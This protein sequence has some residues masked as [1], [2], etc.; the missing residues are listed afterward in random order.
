MPA[1][2]VRRS[3]LPLLAAA[4]LA[5]AVR[6]AAAH[7]GWS[8]YASDVE[9][10]LTGTV[11]EVYF[12]MPHC[13]LRLGTPEKTWTCVLAPLSRMTNR[14]LPDGSIKAGDTVTLVGYAS[15]TVPD[16]MRAE[17][18]TVAGKTVELR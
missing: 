3:L 5:L 15:R 2:L 10:E 11:A 17:R 6:P 14:G 12:G 7:H 9:I 4:P 13:T 8:G 16:E 18:I 1:C